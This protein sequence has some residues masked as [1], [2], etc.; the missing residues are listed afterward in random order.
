[1][2]LAY[3]YS[4]KL[5]KMLPRLLAAKGVDLIF[6]SCSS[7]GEYLRPFRYY[8]KVIDFMD[9]DSE[10]WR[11]FALASAFPTS[12]IYQLEHQRLRRVEGAV[13][14][15]SVSSIFGARALGE[16][17]KRQ[18]QTFCYPLRRLTQ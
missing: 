17:A 3:F 14:K 4:P 12:L 5:L 8:A 18:E 15:W 13:E 10:K 2:T 16:R 1:M 11:V 9:V 7:T 6:A